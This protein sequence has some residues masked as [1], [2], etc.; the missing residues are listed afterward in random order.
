MSNFSFYLPT[1]I[2]F[3]E[4]VLANAAEEVKGLGGSK[5]LLVTDK[6]VM[7][8]DLATPVIDSLKKANLKVTIFD[9][10]KSNPRD[11]DCLKAAE[12]GKSEGVDVLVAVGGGSPMDTAKT[13]G[14]LLTSGGTVHDYVGAQLLKKPILPLVCIPTTAGTGS[15][16]TFFAV[17]TDIAKKIKMSI[18]D[19]RLCASVA[20]VDPVITKTLPAKLTASTGMDALTHAIEAYTCKLA[21]PITD[22]TAIYAIKL[23]SSSLRDAVNDG[24]DLQA[25]TSMMLGSLIAGIAFGN[26]D[27]AG[28]H[29]M[30]EA[31]GGL[32]DTPH[33]VANSIFL[34]YVMEYNVPGDIKKHA[35]IARAMGIDTTGMSEQEAASAG[36]EA[37]KQL[38]KDVGIP[39]FKDLEKVDVNDFEFLAKNSAENIS[40]ESNCRPA[41]ENDYLELFKKAYRGY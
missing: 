21:S 13:V 8:N 32:Y 2:E 19:T 40:T 9:D 11:V 15:E 36:A 5:V 31:I 3:G 4:G 37:V 33:G 16:V 38:S 25:R 6:G 18:L 12:L 27:V 34:P 14:A 26:S 7:D 35:D 29:C 20:L 39:L 10:V 41:D 22:A 28:V 23:I 24:N 30:A 1:R 17:I